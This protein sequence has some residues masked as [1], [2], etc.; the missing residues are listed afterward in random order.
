MNYKFAFR[1][2]VL[3][4]LVFA[5]PAV[6][7]QPAN[8]PA[9]PPDVD[10]ASNLWLSFDWGEGEPTPTSADY[11]FAGPGTLRVVDAFCPGDRFEVYVNGNLVGT[12]SAPGVTDCDYPNET[13]DPEVAEQDPAYSSGSFDLGGGT[14]HVTVVT[15][16]NPFE[17]GGAFLRYDGPTL[18]I[19]TL[20]TWGFALLAL[21]LAAGGLLLVRRR[22]AAA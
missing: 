15:S 20:S 5:M 14:H 6:A 17:G 21:A 3:A 1:L 2:G 12:T 16:V 9:G 18:A 22:R 4:A 10:T 8:G 19:P 11:V 7:A 13:D